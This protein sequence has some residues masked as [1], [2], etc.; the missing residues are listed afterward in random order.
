RVASEL[1]RRENALPQDSTP[2]HHGTGLRE[3]KNPPVGPS[4]G[5]VASH[6]G[7]SAPCSV[8]PG[9][10]SPPI[11]VLIQPGCAEFTLIGVSRSSCASCTVKAFTAVLEAP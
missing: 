3:L 7:V 5:K 6:T 4:A 1:W 11:S 9:A 8:V 2:T 10:S